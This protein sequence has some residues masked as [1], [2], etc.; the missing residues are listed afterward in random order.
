MVATRGRLSLRLTTEPPPPLTDAQ[1]EAARCAVSPTGAHHWLV[2]EDASAGICEHCEAER[3]FRVRQ[4]PLPVLPKR[5]RE[6]LKRWLNPP[7]S[8]SPKHHRQKDHFPADRGCAV[9]PS[10]LRCPLER[11]RYDDT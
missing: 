8:P 5:D 4:E 10:C 7:P 9:S 3:A 1:R 6:K 11:C 2:L